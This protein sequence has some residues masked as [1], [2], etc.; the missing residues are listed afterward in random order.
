[1][2]TLEHLE[3][4]NAA[5]TSGEWSS[6]YDGSSDWSVGLKQDPQDLRVCGVH[7]FQGDWDQGR[8]NAE[9]IASAANHFSAMLEV[10]KA[11]KDIVSDARYQ[12]GLLPNLE[13]AL[14]ALG[15]IK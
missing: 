13:Q 4:L 1:M 5:R 3:K 15:K 2:A 14:K 11:A 10:C 9:F 6:V 12:F 8:A 7:R